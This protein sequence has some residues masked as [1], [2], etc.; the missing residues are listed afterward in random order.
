MRRIV[1]A[2]ADGDLVFENIS[3]T[4]PRRF[5]KVAASFDPL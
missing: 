2:E 1:K 4:V 5:F 3:A